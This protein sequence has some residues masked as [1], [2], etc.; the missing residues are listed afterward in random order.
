MSCNF[1]LPSVA[2][3]V[4]SLHHFLESLA[5]R[6]ESARLL[7]ASAQ[8]PYIPI[9]VY[10]WTACRIVYLGFSAEWRIVA[11]VDTGREW[12]ELRV[13]SQEVDVAV[14]ISYIEVAP[15]AFL[16]LLFSRGTILG[17]SA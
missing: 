9:A 8:D 16:S 2:A 5:R 17:V 4:F 3:C 11:A 15:I 14:P 1:M 12:R 7:V 6:Q 13:A 10:G